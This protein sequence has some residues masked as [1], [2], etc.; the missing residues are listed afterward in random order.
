MLF[1]IS[2]PHQDMIPNQGEVKKTSVI[3]GLDRMDI[4]DIEELF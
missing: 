1:N 3:Y 4:L 2:T